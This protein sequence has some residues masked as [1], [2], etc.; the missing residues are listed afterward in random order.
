[1]YGVVRSETACEDSVALGGKHHA[2][3][4]KRHSNRVGRQ[5]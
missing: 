4:I 3:T 1:M 5:V 2:K